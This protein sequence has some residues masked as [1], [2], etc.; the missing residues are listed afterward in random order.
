MS[1]GSGIRTY[2]NNLAFVIIFINDKKG[3][4]DKKLI[5]CFMIQPS[6]QPLSLSNP[7][8]FYEDVEHNAA[9]ASAVLPR[10]RQKIKVV[11]V[12][13]REWPIT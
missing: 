3:K 4:M 2:R 11:G 9:E 6:I 13:V 7:F 1:P 5:S 8:K 10:G 12:G